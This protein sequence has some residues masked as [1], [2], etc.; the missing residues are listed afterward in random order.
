MWEN[1]LDI[2]SDTQSTLALPISY[3]TNL[4]TAKL[5]GYLHSITFYYFIIKGRSKLREWIIR[6]LI[7]VACAWKRC[8]IL[9]EATIQI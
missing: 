3:D 9:V 8:R 6:R 7:V 1:N 2:V 5:I 4:I